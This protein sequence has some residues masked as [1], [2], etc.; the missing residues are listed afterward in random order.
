MDVITR[1]Q[2]L[3]QVLKRYF[4][5]QPCKRGH[6]S[7]RYVNKSVCV[8]CDNERPRPPD[9]AERDRQRHIQNAEK[10]R[11]RA[12][13]W[14]LDNPDRFRKARDAWAQKN[15]DHLR[16]LKVAQNHRRRARA[17][18]NM[19]QE[20]GPVDTDSLLASQRHRCA[21]C[22][23]SLTGKKW[24]IDHIHPL[25]RGGAN[26]RKN[27]QICCVSCNLSKGAR[28]PIDYARGL[29]MLI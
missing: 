26:D 11:L 27:L 29:G 23:T 6:L 21:Y 10:N 18:G 13:N 14:R 22:R 7:E 1:K 19:S 4:T 24:H 28:D 8:A 16:G 20:R 15:G 17:R 5:G 9:R 12:K 2:A 25:A 3:S